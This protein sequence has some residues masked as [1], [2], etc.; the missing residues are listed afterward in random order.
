MTE[1]EKIL[2]G[3]GTGK[4][5][6]MVGNT[7]LEKDGLFVQHQDEY[8]F[9]E[10]MLVTYTNAG[11]DEAVDRLS[12][13]LDMAKKDVENRVMTIHGF[14][15][16][17]LDVEW[18]DVVDWRDE[19]N[20]CNK[21]DL[22]YGNADDDDDVMASD[23]EEGNLLL[24]IY[25]WLQSN[26]LSIEDHDQF[27]GGWTGDGDIEDLLR[28]WEIYKHQNDLVGWGDMVEKVVAQ[29]IRYLKE[30]G[31]GDTDLDDEREYLLSC[32]EDDDFVASSVRGNKG[33]ADTKVLYVDECQ[34]LTRNQW[35]WYLCQ[36]LA[37]EEVYLGGDDDQTI[38][39]WGGADPEQLLQEEG[40]VNVL[41]TTYRLPE[42]VWKAC[43]ACIEQVDHRQ[44]KDIQPRDDEGE[45]IA[46]KRPR[47]GKLMEHIGESD[48]VMILFR[49]RYLI[50]D[51]RD[52]LH[53]YGIP[54]DNMSTF[55]T[56]KNYVVKI[57]DAL[58]AVIEEPV[59]PEDAAETL[60]A[61]SAKNM[62][63]KGTP[64]LA[65]YAVDEDMERDE[66]F[67]KF[68]Y[69]VTRPKRF[70]EWYPK[71]LYNLADDDK[72]NVDLKHELNWFQKEAIIGNLQST[73]RERTPEQV[74]I[75]TIHSAKGKEA[76]TVIVGTDSTETIV[77]NMDADR[78]EIDDAERRVLYVAMS[79]AERKLVLAE[80]VFNQSTSLRINAV[81]GDNY[82]QV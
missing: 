77:S 76:D 68:D 7:D 44:T 82:D 19:M 59:V 10:Q 42:N 41:S 32:H 70:V 65:E 50:D 6:T 40:D 48:D 67:D 78:G 80:N 43:E 46:L 56:W 17:Y 33:F 75:G 63:D 74:R 24:Q 60:I 72:Y 29:N 20:F 2:G 64:G 13:L 47:I 45:F 21:H 27:P 55:D 58:R 71:R 14:C 52:E 36:K 54:Y 81:L 26:R 57:R 18:G 23:A 79:R 62:L 5:T 31:V 22:E 73:Y 51:F 37:A 53:E 69:P 25:R 11:V 16:R 4:T 8:D 34:D 61:C 9:D 28:K 12:E 38:F 3:P 49:A 35:N 15:Y 1:I 30:G 66:F 39:E